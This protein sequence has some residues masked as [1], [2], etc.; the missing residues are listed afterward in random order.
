M[1][2]FKKLW[3]KVA[4]VYSLIIMALFFIFIAVLQ[5]TFLAY[6]EDKEY[7]MYSDLTNNIELF[8]ESKEEI[9]GKDLEGFIRE[10]DLLS[11]VDILLYDDSGK[12]ILG[13]KKYHEL[14]Q[15]Y[16]LHIDMKDG[17][18]IE[19]RDNP[20]DHD[21]FILER[22]YK[23]IDGT[24]YL[25]KQ[26]DKYTTFY[27]K[28]ER[29]AISF[30][31]LLSTLF[32]F[33]SLITSRWLLNPIFK[34]LQDVKKI[35]IEGSTSLLTEQ[36]PEEEFKKI[37]QLQ[38]SF[39][40]KIRNY[41]SREKKFISNASHE[42]LTPVTVIKGYT[43]VL[44]WGSDDKEVL[45]SALDTIENETERMEELMRSLMVL[46]K[47]EETEKNILVPL[48]MKKIVEEEGK[49]LQG[50]YERKIRVKSE[51]SIILGEEQL[52]KLLLGE[53]VKNAVKY[54]QEDIKINLY[55]DKNKVI[56]I[57]KDQGEGIS[58]DYLKEIFQRFSQEDNSKG[59]KGFG[60][61]LA[62]VKDISKLHQGMVEIKSVQEEGTEVK[63]TFPRAN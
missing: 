48:D 7:P 2:L 15:N 31:V 38:N 19:P 57:I 54:S 14:L 6:F 11:K 36:Y 60:L 30:A 47:I 39:I 21:Y 63:V 28:M 24:L 49:R 41:I 34:I 5:N 29:F 59:S 25:V 27:L 18:I 45:N 37:V 55:T 23:K 35:E 42:L 8:I 50:V 16:E 22:K 46:S 51:K 44:R 53:V 62:I 32:I 26:I 12:M 43:E 17:M 33:L 40:K 10:G 56:L 4:I 52:L 1:V 20:D 58:S 9:N 61:G 3:H 13:D